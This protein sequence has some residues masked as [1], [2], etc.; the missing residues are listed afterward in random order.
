MF[1]SGVNGCGAGITELYPDMR[2][3]VRID[4]ALMSVTGDYKKAK[5]TRV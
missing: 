2:F 3:D 1:G 4:A 5:G